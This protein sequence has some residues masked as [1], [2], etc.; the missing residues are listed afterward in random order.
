MKT[1]LITGASGHLGSSVTRLFLDKGYRVVA[2]VAR[3]ENLGFLKH[4]RLDIRQA[5]LTDE[6]AAN[7]LVQYAIH[8]YGPLEAG[9]LLA[10]GFATGSLRNTTGKH[11]STQMSLNF[12][13]AYFV[14]RP[15]FQHLLQQGKGN[16]VF[17]G[18]RPAL[19]PGQGKD[20]V[21]YGL[22]KSLLFRTAELMNEE[23][24]GTAVTATVI[25][26]SIIDTPVNRKAM[27]DAHFNDWVKPGQL[28]GILH[29]IVSEPASAI[30]ES[31]VKVYNNA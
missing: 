22:S 16:I 8:T 25:V 24:R 30:R 23:A 29:F 11:I 27:P 4:E 3:K 14:A 28:A 17:V 12:N 7:E 21:A 26:P 31:V 20:M 10:G 13:T 19:Q 5:D 9:L 15:M 2:V 1:I 6:A 18:A